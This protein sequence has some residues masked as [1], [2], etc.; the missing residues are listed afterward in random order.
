[1]FA[2]PTKIQKRLPVVVNKWWRSWLKTLSWRVVATTL[3]SFIAYFVTGSLV[4]ASTVIG[5]DVI[6]KSLAY[7]LHEKAWAST[8][9]GKTLEERKGCVVWFTGL[10]GSGKTTVADMVADKLKDKLLPVARIDGDVARRTFSSDL[11]FSA[12]DRAE[13]CRRAIH[14]AS[15]LKESS[16]VLAS[17]ISPYRSIREYARKLCRHQD[18]LIVQVSCPI[19]ECARRDPKGM[20]AQL[21]EGKFKGSPF[22][23]AHPD[24]PYEIEHDADL[25]LF[26][27]EETVEKSADKVIGMLVEQGYL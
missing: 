13:N 10:S 14:A 1:M 18:V 25:Y 12:E 11:G 7:W 19:E 15:Y 16:I 6:L 24:A 21:D 9:L 17:F 23:G 3:L 22:T 5:L 8:T 27:N 20:Y 26:T 2:P 4:V